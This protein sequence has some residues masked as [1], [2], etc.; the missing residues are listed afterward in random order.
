[1]TYHQEITSPK[2]QASNPSTARYVNAYCD[3]PE[4]IIAAFIQNAQ[5]YQ[6]NK[7]IRSID[8]LINIATQAAEARCRC[9]QVVANIPAYP[10][11][12]RTNKKRY[13]ISQRR[14]YY[15]G[16]SRNPSMLNES[17]IT[18]DDMAVTCFLSN[19]ELACFISKATTGDFRDDI[20]A[21]AHHNNVIFS[22]HKECLVRDESGY[23]PLTEILKDA[24]QL[25]LR[26]YATAFRTQLALCNLYLSMAQPVAG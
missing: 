10:H 17:S 2:A 8:E 7:K 26:L 25:V 14:L 18:A 22:E 21:D 15:A 16:S 20:A 19:Y 4:P 11:I 24:S 12:Y 9:M 3:A 5:Q 6:N 1:M 13:A 23:L